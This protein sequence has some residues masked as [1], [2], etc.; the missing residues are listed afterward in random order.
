MLFPPV[1]NANPDGLLAI[2]GNL[3]IATLRSAYRSGVFPWPVDDFPLLWFAPPRRSILH[4]D[5]FHISR[6]L[7]RTLRHTPFEIRIDTNFEQVI[8]ECAVMREDE[9]GTWITDELTEA[10]IRLHRAGDAHSVETYLDGQ[11]VGGLYGVSFGA[12]FAGESMFYRVNDASKAALV[13]LVAHLQARGATWL[14]TQM[15]TPLFATFGACEI[16]RSK[17]MKMMKGALSQPVQ[18]FD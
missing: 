2:G 12:Y 4:F 18:L 16:P 7:R 8:R 9:E 1:E 6:R 13:H 11:L 10:Y 17:F 5:R 3:E 15:I 14:D